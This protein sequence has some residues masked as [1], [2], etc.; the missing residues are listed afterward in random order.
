MTPNYLIKRFFFLS[1]FFFLANKQSH[2]GWR[3]NEIKRRI[4]SSL[5]DGLAY[6]SFPVQQ[7]WYLKCY[8]LTLTVTNSIIMYTQFKI[9]LT[10]VVGLT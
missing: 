5:E 3:E 6:T 7:R 9:N 1:S 4:V 10:Y 8:V 2:D